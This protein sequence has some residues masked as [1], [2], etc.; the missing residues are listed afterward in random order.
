MFKD[1]KPSAWE[2]NVQPGIDQEKDRQEKERGEK[3]PEK[4]IDTSRQSAEKTAVATGSKLDGLKAF[5]EKT[6]G[7]AKKFFGKKE[8]SAKSG[9]L[10]DLENKLKAKELLFA[11]VRER[12]TSLAQFQETSE[13]FRQA[14]GEFEKQLEQVF[15]QAQRQERLKTMENLIER[16]LQQLEV[17]L[18]E[19]LKDIKKEE[20]GTDGWRHKDQERDLIREK[21]NTLFIDLF[22]VQKEETA[23]ID[24]SWYKK[25]SEDWI[26]EEDIQVPDGFEAFG[27]G[28]FTIE[29]LLNEK[30]RREKRR[31][32]V[33]EGTQSKEES[34]YK[35]QARDSEERERINKKAEQIRKDKK[36]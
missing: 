6:V 15:D 21:M 25:N 34:M 16:R 33:K 13:R 7:K 9:E 4:E 10:A 29:N 22:A 19:V 27:Q 2:L 30:G 11:S 1:N 23:L 17:R 12:L 35:E 36:E 20:Y 28:T 8:D 18:K 24:K 26:P 32:Q 3:S 31:K 14:K 5:W